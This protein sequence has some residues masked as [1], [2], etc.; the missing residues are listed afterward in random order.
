[1]KLFNA[2]MLLAVGLPSFL[3]AQDLCLYLEVERMCLIG[4]PLELIVFLDFVNRK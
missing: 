4:Q 1:M 3:W 2:G